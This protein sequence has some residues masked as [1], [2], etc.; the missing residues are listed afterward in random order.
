MIFVEVMIIHRFEDSGFTFRWRVLVLFR[1]LSRDVQGQGFEAW[2]LRS[3]FGNREC[4]IQHS[5][6]SYEKI[7]FRSANSCDTT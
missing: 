3:G 2:F 6:M 4:I 1:A 7:G 5:I